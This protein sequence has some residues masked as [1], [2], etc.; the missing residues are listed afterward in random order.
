MNLWR[1]GGRRAWVS[2][3]KG[4]KLNK[5]ERLER[6]RKRDSGARMEETVELGWKL[7]N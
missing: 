4:P 5:G 1:E 6:V 2:K 7:G 3:E